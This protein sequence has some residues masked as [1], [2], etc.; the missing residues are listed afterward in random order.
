MA[1]HP[2]TNEL[3][4]DITGTNDALSIVGE[5]DPAARTIVVAHPTSPLVLAAGVNVNSP[6]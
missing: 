2:T 1:A 4:I 6:A 3:T 5:V